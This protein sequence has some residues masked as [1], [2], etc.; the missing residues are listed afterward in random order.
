ML[1]MP[2]KCYCAIV[3]WA[4]GSQAG[5]GQVLG[6]YLLLGWWDGVLWM[7]CVQSGWNV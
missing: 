1:C 4:G 7:T 5:L 2:Y 6:V 3:T